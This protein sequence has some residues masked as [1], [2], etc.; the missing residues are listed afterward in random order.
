MSNLIYLDQYRASELYKVLHHYDVAT[1]KHGIYQMFH[2][3]G[4]PLQ[5]HWKDENQ[6]FGVFLVY[7]RMAK[8]L[9]RNDFVQ[10]IM[11]SKVPQGVFLNE[12]EKVFVNNIEQFQVQANLLRDFLL[13]LADQFDYEVWL[14]EVGHTVQFYK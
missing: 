10:A 4:S 5:I 6:V 14:N 13:S 1:V 3:F 2:L 9:S 8:R 12:E 11:N 7:F